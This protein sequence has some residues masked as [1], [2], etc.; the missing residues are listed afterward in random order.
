MADTDRLRR[1]P[2]ECDRE[3]R[4]VPH[5]STT[6]PVRRQPWAA[7]E[8]ASDVEGLRWLAL[9]SIIGERNRVRVSDDELTVGLWNGTL[10]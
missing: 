3:A 10:S 1:M 7:I 4:T 6:S 9:A 5:V 8:L 2:Q